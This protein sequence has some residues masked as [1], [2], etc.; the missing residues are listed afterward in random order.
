MCSGQLIK[1]APDKFDTIIH[2]ERNKASHK[3]KINNLENFLRTVKSGKMAYGCCI[4]SSDE[5]ATEIACAAGFDFVWI[6]GEH[7]QMDRNVAMRHL[8]SVK[9]TGVASFYRVPSCDHTEIKKV[10][11][12]CP[13]GIIIPMVM[14]EEDARR[15]VAAC[16]Y[17][18]HGGNRGCGFR[19]GWD[20]GMRS[21]DEYLAES[22]HDPLVIIQ[23][24]H[25]DAAR[26]LDQILAV[27]GV[28]SILIGPYD[29]SMSMG[30]PGRFDDPE[31]SE[32]FDTV[33]AKVVAKGIPLG[34]YCESGFADWRRRG[35][36]YMSVKNDTNAMLWGF[37]ESLKRALT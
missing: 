30:K 26:R 24:E 18:I 23:L 28:D 8:V 12:F 32:A 27:P 13:A 21:T 25:I 15:A 20:Y 7:G 1:I 29:F 17:P 22:A 11:D 10:I 3:V 37:R 35:V 9:G 6:D 33:C 34:V 5:S 14:D 2:D 31:V 19:R 36:S 4:T 16:R